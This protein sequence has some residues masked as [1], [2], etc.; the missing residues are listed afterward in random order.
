MQAW[1]VYSKKAD[2]AAIA[3]R[4]GIDP[5]TARVIRNRGLTE[6]EAIDRYLNGSLRDLHDPG[7]ML[8][9]PEAVHTLIEAVK[10]REGIRIIGDYDIDGICSV[11]ILYRGLLRIG[12][13]VDYDVPDRI[14][15]GYGLNIRLVEEAVKDHRGVLLTCDNGIAATEAIAYAKQCGLTVVVTDHHEV[16]YTEA[17][18]EK[19]YELP[20]ADVVVDPKQPGET[21][22]FRELCGAGIAYKLVTL[23][24]EECGIPVKEAEKLLEFA[25][26]ATVGDVVELQDENRILVREGLK[27][28][29]ETSNPGLRALIELTGLGNKTI[30][31]YHIGFVLGPCLNASGRL[32]SAK[33]GIRMLCEKDPAEAAK[34]AGDLK[35]LNDERKSMTDRAVKEGID[36]VLREGREHDP[37]LVILLENC[38]ESIAGIVAGKVRER[39]YRPTIV[40]TKTEEGLKGSGRSIEEYNLFEKLTQQKDLLTR[41]GGHAMAAGLSLPEENLEPLRERLKASAGL[42]EAD[43]TQKVWIDVPMPVDYASEKVIKDL[44][45]LAPFGKGNEKP[46]F[47]DKNLMIDAVQAM[48]KE[49]QYTRMI[50]TKDN[51]Y[52]VRAVGFFP[53]GELIEA[54]RDGKRVDCT[55]YPEIN[56]YR[57]ISQ[58]QISVTGYKIHV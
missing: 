1:Y 15:D 28:V 29:R 7:Q 10:Q 42:S 49:N 47:A 13:D 3:D 39:F 21:Y 38:H 11:Y 37:V 56:E 2:F 16:P 22:P 52:S 26:I 40:L 36:S 5:V 43:L 45:R 27:R 57:G 46:V 34:L 33:R 17:G 12:A 48:G 53:P 9:L 32:D 41:F 55:Y 54:Q 8:H 35:A 31:A 44:E 4:F 58:L 23:L 19:N 20:P 50:L 30:G 6:M 25:A 51:G 24:Y 14:T 18:G